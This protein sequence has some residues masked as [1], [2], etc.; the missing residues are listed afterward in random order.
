MRRK[1]LTRSV[2]VALAFFWGLYPHVFIREGFIANKPS[3]GLA[4]PQ[5]KPFVGGFNC[6][7]YVVGG[8]YYSRAFLSANKK[9]LRALLF[10]RALLIFVYEERAY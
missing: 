10:R 2:K 8:L 1:S 9:L 5:I 7:C 4:Y 3:I 6:S